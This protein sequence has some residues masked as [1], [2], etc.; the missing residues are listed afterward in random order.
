MNVKSLLVLSALVCA[1]GSHA[2]V[3][4]TAAPA[5]PHVVTVKQF[6]AKGDGVHD[7][8]NAIQAALDALHRRGGGVLRVPRGTYLLNSYKPTPHPWFFYN[9]R[10]GSN[11]LLQGEPGAKL[12]QGP[13]GR[14]VM[15]SIPGAGE[16][17]TTVLVFGSPNYTINTF[18][19]KSKNGGFMPLQPTRAGARSVRLAAPTQAA[20]FKAGDYVAIYSTDPAGKDVIPSESTQVVSVGPRGV[21]GLKHALARS[22]SAPVVARVTALA[23]VNVGV[24]NLT[25]QGSTPLN[26]NEVFGFAASGNTFISDTSVSDGNVHGLSMNDVRGV[27]FRHNTVTSAGPYYAGL[28]LPQRNSQDV[29]IIGN[30]FDVG[31]VGFGEYGAHWVISGNTIRVHSDSLKSGAAVFFGGYDVEFSRNHIRGSTKSVPLMADWVGI[32]AYADYV[33]RIRIIDNIVDCRAE[34]A[35]C[36]NI[37]GPDTIVRG[38]VFNVTGSFG[39]AI[40]VEGPR[41]QS[42]RIEQ[43]TVHAAGGT[44]IVLNSGGPDNSVVTGNM[45][46]GPGP[47]GI[48]VASPSTPKPGRH[49]ISG[50]TITGFRTAL[51]IDRSKHPHARI[52]DTPA[53]A[54]PG[55]PSGGRAQ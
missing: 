8:T 34:G 43:N 38:N 4:A 17:A 51:S 14:A 31:A 25:I 36:L 18:Q 55:H 27:D 11:T 6:G 44:G 16:V 24:R 3:L 26:V 12:L 15:A 33:G 19:D 21:L 22:F 32:D 39:E 30:T 54:M 20:G 50:N 23:T 28:E 9:L 37:A 47:F 42:I 46:T 45:F 13:L 7:D 1:V 53:K 5:G 29:A 40:L 10:A 41:P 48:Y 52:S 2:I 35:N 49:V